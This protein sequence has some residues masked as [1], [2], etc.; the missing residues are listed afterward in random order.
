M[1]IKSTLVS[2]KKLLKAEASIFH[3]LFY[4]FLRLSP[5][6]QLAH[7]FKNNELSENDK[8]RLPKDFDLVLTKYELFGDVINQQFEAWWLDRGNKLFQ[9][10]VKSKKVILDINLAK[11]EG[12]TIKEISKLINLIYSRNQA[13]E[14][15]I[16]IPKNKIQTKA[17]VSRME[18]T[19][20]IAYADRVSESG[21]Y[22][23]NWQIAAYL[24]MDSKY[25]LGLDPT[26]KLKLNNEE[27]RYQLTIL[28]S[29]SVR[30]SVI[31]CENAAR[32][33]FPSLEKNSNAL[34][35]DYKYISTVLKPIYSYI[36]SASLNIGKNQITKDLGHKI[37][38]DALKEW[39]SLSPKQKSQ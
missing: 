38:K 2:S 34:K 27:A 13:V 36:H 21:K 11:T 18:S 23:S 10:N 35:F 7:R 3:L 15:A 32:G 8:V 5:S 28:I 4:G 12:Q 24:H 9:Q 29:K 30:E 16:L 14:E 39:Y 17:L 22:L 25:L 37:F 19:M 6:Y 26:D 1:Q 20:A 33:I 31:I